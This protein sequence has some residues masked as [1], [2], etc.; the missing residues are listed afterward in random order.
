MLSRRIRHWLRLLLAVSLV[1]APTRA[2]SAEPAVQPKS[3]AATGEHP[4]EEAELVRATSLYDTGQYS[5]CVDAFDRLVSLDGTKR[6]RTPTKVEAARTY[7]AACLIGVGRTTDAERV[8]RAAVLENPQMRA[9]DALLFPEA[10]VELFLRVRE[11][12]MDEIRRAEQKRMQDAET[13][14]DR[15]RALRERERQRIVQLLAFAEKEIVIERHSRWIAAV[16]FGVGQFQNG[17]TGLGWLFLVSESAATGLLV[18]SLYMQAFYQSK[19]SDPKVS[20]TDLDVRTRSAITL[21]SIGGYS[22]L[23]LGLLGIAEAE[24]AFVPEVRV[25][26]K[27]PLPAEL[28]G[29][30][31]KPAGADKAMSLR[32]LPWT[33]NGIV[34][35]AILGSF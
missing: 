35:G 23:G 27:R 2:Q 13:R 34:G 29:P 10:V 14:A 32:L 21:Q 19:Y 7:Y 24:L 1:D 8:F 18:G 26:R 30:S 11:S 16:P 4:S 6:L 3:T 31:A 9:P 28:R 15:E 25:E 33:G 5:V 12:M 20:R 22:L 17:D